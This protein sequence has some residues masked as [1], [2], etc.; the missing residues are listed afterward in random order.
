MT[1]LQTKPKPLDVDFRKSTI[2]IVDMQNAFASKGGMSDIAG[3]DIFV[4]PPRSIPTSSP[5][6]AVP[7]SA[8]SSPRDTKKISTEKIRAAPFWAACSPKKTLSA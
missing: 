2:I 6:F 1:N 3:A 4:G 5:D 8:C 7:E